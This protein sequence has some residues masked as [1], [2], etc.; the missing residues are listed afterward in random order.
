MRKNFFLLGFFFAVACGASAT[1]GYRITITIEGI[2][3]SVLYL[4]NY[5]GD[6]TY[7]SDT[8]YLTKKGS[9]VFEDG[10]PL[11][12]G[13]YIIAGQNNIKLFELLIDR[14][15]SF[16]I[17]ALMPDLFNSL[18]FEN[19]IENDLFYKYIRMNV[20]SQKELERLNTLINTIPASSDSVEGIRKEMEAIRVKSQDDRDQMIRQSAGT[21][22]SVML[23]AMIEPDPQKAIA[24]ES[25]K[26]DTVYMYQYYKQHFWENFDVSD[27]RLLRTPLY[28]KRLETYFNRVVIQHPDSI[29]AEIEDFIPKVESNPETFK[30]VVWYLTYKFETSMVMGYDEIFVHMV[31]AY[32]T[33]EKAFWA[34]ASVVRSLNERANALRNV[35]IGV[36]APNL[37]LIDTAGS[38]VSLHHQ[39]APYLFVLFYEMDCGHCKK[40]LAELKSWYLD[41]T[42]GVQVFAVST[43]TSLVK[44]KEYITENRLPFIHANA[45][46]SITP[47]Y[48]E[49]YDISTTPTLF[50]LDENKKIIAKRLKVSQ[51][52]SFLMNHYNKNVLNSARSE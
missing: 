14:E 48:H 24:D 5:Y 21:F 8:S 11:P 26:K 3:D 44:W 38:F 16:S 22:L 7:L 30:Y 6:K 12:G 29:I 4:A 36:T 17:S 18:E 50:L 43:D 41:D 31:D 51:M 10:N 20:S 9:F 23:K 39:A 2:E 49:L 46:R 40:E 33:T 32:Y 13:I 15:Q 19:S 47:R 25:L 34:D 37:I 1:S 27:D 42:L 45:T 52:V 28:H 35:L